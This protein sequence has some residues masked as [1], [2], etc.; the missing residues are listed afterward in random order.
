MRILVTGA[1]G[2]IGA[3]LCKLLQEQGI[4]VLG[5]D[6]FNDYY[7]PELKMSRIENLVKEPHETILKIDLLDKT[8]LKNLFEQYKPNVVV[9]LAAQAGVRLK[10]SEFYKYTDSNIIGFANIC[11]LIKE[12]EI[13]NFLYASSSSVYGNLNQ[14]PFK[15]SSSGLQPISV[16]GVTKLFDELYGFAYFRNTQIK[17]VGMRFFTVYGPWGRPDMAY[18]KII[19]SLL[20]KTEFTRFGNGELKRDFT[21][22]E[23]TVNSI[24]KLIMKVFESKIHGQEIYNVGGGNPY[25]LNELINE[26]E[27]QFAQKL[28]IKELDASSADVKITYASYEKLQNYIN[29]APKT[30]LK[31]GISNLLAWVKNPGV[32]EKILNWSK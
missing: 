20:N 17:S 24:Y 4:E 22:V 31:E 7:S 6:N 2:F 9:H 15:E 18:F 23:D 19:N 3:H 13:T 27:R 12:F 11:E 5:I 8:A 26:M 32:T 29:Y 16:Y 30:T 10:D 25:S 21:Y 14:V 28:V 1:A